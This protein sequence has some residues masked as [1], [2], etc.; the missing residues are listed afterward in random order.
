MSLATIIEDIFVK[1]NK[2]QIIKQFAKEQIPIMTSFIPNIG[3]VVTSEFQAIEHIIKDHRTVFFYRK[4][5]TFIM[6]LEDLTY[7]QRIKFAEEIR[8][9]AKDTFGYV[10]VD[11]VDRL[12]NINKQEFFAKLIIA[13][14]HNFITIDD[15]FR[16]HSLL[17]RIPYTDLAKLPQY[18]YGYYDESGG[19]ELLFA[20][21]ALNFSYI[22]TE[23]GTKY[24]L[25]ALGEKLL[26]FGLG[27]RLEVQRERGISLEP[28]TAS[29]EELDQILDT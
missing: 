23:N 21:G 13:R 11:M 27:I 18:Q 8:E 12:D 19:S 29:E 2:G 5:K 3:G 24:I 14:I 10:L 25:S 16:L 9:K 7:E 22:S 1:D 4:F 20:V 28:P 15:F 17:E 6:E 26:C